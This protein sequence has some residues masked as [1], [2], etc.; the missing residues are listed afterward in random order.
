MW[1][2]VLKYQIHKHLFQVANSL[3]KY[4]F[5]VTPGGAARLQQPLSIDIKDFNIGL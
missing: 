4:S 2:G 3:G 5:R 1:T